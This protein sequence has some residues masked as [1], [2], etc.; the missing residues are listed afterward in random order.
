[1]YADTLTSHTASCPLHEHVTIKNAHRAQ[2]SQLIGNND[3]LM[4]TMMTMMMMTI[5]MTSEMNHTSELSYRLQYTPTCA[6]AVRQRITIIFV[7][8]FLSAQQQH[9]WAINVSY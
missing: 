1:M 6:P 7:F 5:M 2:S 3:I 8:V 9:R 4:I